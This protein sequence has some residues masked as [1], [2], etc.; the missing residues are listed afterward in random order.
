MIDP[1]VIFVPGLGLDEREWKPVRATL[2]ASSLVLLLPSMGQPATR[3]QDLRAHAQANRVLRLLPTGVP[4]ILVAHSA[5]CPVV[6]QVATRS[7][8]VVGLVLVGPVTDPAAATWPAILVQW[9]RTAIHEHLWEIPTLARQWWKTGPVSMLT[10]MNAVRHFRTDH[11]LEEVTAPVHIVRGNTDRIA[12]HPWSTTLQ[13]VSGGD[14]STVKGAAHRVPL[15]HPDAVAAAIQDILC[16]QRRGD[17]PA[18]HRPSAGH[19]KQ[20]YV[21]G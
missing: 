9:A 16:G 1:L 2:N 13:Q 11:A 3:G 12:T 5:S 10:G 7:S 20:V 19:L 6:A 21:L 8:T 15:T 17:H 14:L 18:L 4:I